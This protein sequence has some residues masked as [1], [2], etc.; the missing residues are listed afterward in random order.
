MFSL[1]C[2]RRTLWCK[3]AADK[4]KTWHDRFDSP[5]D[6]YRLTQQ[7]LWWR[8]LSIFFFTWYCCQLDW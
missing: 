7:Q 4:T 6:S 5:I 8:R 2:N 3:T 1:R